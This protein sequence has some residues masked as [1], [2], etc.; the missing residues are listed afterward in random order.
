MVNIWSPLT[1]I[2]CLFGAVRS[3]W[4]FDLAIYRYDNRICTEP[5]I[6]KMEIVRGNG[7]CHSFKD[8]APFNGY[9]ITWA[10]HKD[11][12]E[13][14]R[15][16]GECMVLVWEQH[17]C[18]GRYLGYLSYAN[19]ETL[20]GHCFGDFADDHGVLGSARSMMIVCKKF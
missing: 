4:T 6:G 18:Y 19:N 16:Y 8:N 20:F 2:A 15:R 1:V 11:Y 9:A 3:K 17:G 7:K 10:A 13:T 12:G 5:S 14:P